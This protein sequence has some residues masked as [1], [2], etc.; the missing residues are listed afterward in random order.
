MVMKKLHLLLLSALLLSSCMGHTVSSEGKLVLR[1]NAQKDKAQFDYVLFDTPKEKTNGLSNVK[2][3]EPSIV[4][5]FALDKTESLIWMKDM[6]FS[7]DILF[8]DETKSLI[9]VLPKLEPCEKDK[10]C[11]T[12]NIPNNAKWAIE[13]NAGTLEQYEI[14]LGDTFSL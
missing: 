13:A 7:L 11:T 3:M 10:R 9:G 12:Y 6:E 1:D 5:L 14:E 2:S 8:F 4:A